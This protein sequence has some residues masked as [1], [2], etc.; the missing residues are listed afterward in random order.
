MKKIINRIKEKIEI[1]SLKQRDDLYFINIK[2]EHIIFLLSYLKEQEGF[3]HLAFLQAVDYD[4]YNMFQ[5]TYMLYN[6][7]IKVNLGIKVIIDREKSEMT[8]IHKLWAHAWQ[9][10]RELHE[11][12]G[13]NFPDSPRVDESFVLEGWEEIPPMRRDFDTKE[14]SEKTFYQR[15]G[16]S[17]N[18]PKEYMKEKLYK[19]FVESPKIRREDG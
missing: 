10:Q 4:K 2:E 11:L 14:Y 13:I 5:L 16:R 17:T 3:T 15:P 9:Y 8:S 18:D 19:N 1:V 12:F 7:D 6:Y